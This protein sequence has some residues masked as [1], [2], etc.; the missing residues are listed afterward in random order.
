[1]KKNILF[2]L[3]TALFFTLFSCNKEE[4]DRWN[5]EVKT[6][7]PV[8]ITDISAEFYNEKIPFQE[9]KE[10]Y[11]FFLAPQVP[12]ATY[13][14]KRNNTLERRM[15]KNAI[16]LNKI[17]R[18]EKDLTEL[19]AHVKYYFPKFQNPKVYVFSSATELYQEP[20]LY[21]PDQ[22]ILFIDLSAFMGEKSEYYEGI[23]NYIKKD[24]NPENVIAR[25]SETIAIDYVPVTPDQ[26]KFLDKIINQG[27]LLTLQDAFLPKTLDQYKIG[28]A[29][30]QQEWAVSNEENIWNY[31]VENDLL[32]SDDSNLNERFLN[33]GPFSKF[34]TEI[35][36]KSSPRVG[37]FIGWQICRKYLAEH[38]EVTLQQF[39]Q[40]S[41]TEIFNNTNYKPKN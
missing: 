34:Y 2:L 5:V 22:K 40:K 38:P 25:V 19:F 4:N 24:M 32:F 15:Y 1:M 21:I 3:L 29:K 35:D 18:L 11:S 6:S 31:F 28:Y 8:K 41:A 36:Q 39:L 17:P 9:F 23:D 16:S 14:K 26:N 33:K 12:D 7:E 13:E 30:S 10:K 37:T 20:I 27:K